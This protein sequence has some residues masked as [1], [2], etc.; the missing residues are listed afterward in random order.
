MSVPGPVLMPQPA[1]TWPALPLDA[2][3]ETYATLHMWTQIVGKTRLA[4]APMEN[5]WWQVPLYVTP[6]GL[7]SSAMPHGTRT[8]AVEFDFVDHQLQLRA[9]DGRSGAMPLVAESVADFNGGYREALGALGVDVHI[10]PVPVEV[11]TAIPF[12]EDRVHQSY[13][14]HAA[15]RCWRILVQADRVFKRFRGR[16]LGKQSPSHFFWGSFDL[17]TTRFSGRRAPLHPGGAPNCPDYVMQEAYSHECSSCGFWPGGG[18][19]AEPAFYAY[20]YPAPHGYGDHAIRPA[21]AFYSKEMGE[22][23]LP[24]ESVRTAA[25]PDDALLD[26]LQSTYEAAATLAHWDRAALDRPSEEWHR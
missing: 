12:A 19:I 18:A 4:L 15:Q 21:D 13:D 6:R 11:E 2:W 25:A 24:Y 3:K 26:F 20:A 22:F 23:I 10:H 1:E 5:H 7:T 9:S 14:P 17:A 16:F 8:F